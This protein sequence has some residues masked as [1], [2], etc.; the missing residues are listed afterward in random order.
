MRKY[1]KID[2]GLSSYASYVGCTKDR[3]L[4]GNLAFNTIHKILNTSNQLTDFFYNILLSK[5]YDEIYMFNGRMNNY[6]PL[7]RVAQ[8]LKIK[9]NNL[10]HHAS[11]DR[12]FNNG[13][14]LPIDHIVVGKKINS[15]WKNYKKKYEKMIN[16]FF[17]YWKN[18]QDIFH[19]SF[20]FKKAKRILPEKWNVKKKI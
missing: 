17:L 12:I 15:H 3:D 2:N 19:N 11:R 5:K 18:N 20:I 8:N 6:R 14:N 7:L 16:K 1:K 10:E 4:E 13:S 9:I